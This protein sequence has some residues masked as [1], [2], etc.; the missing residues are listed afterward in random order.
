LGEYLIKN[1]NCVCDG[2]DYDENF[3][4]KA[5][6]KGY[7]NTFKIDLYQN[8]FHLQEQYDLIMFVDI[9]EHLPNPYSILKK[10][11]AENLKK[12]GAGIICL[13]N[14][15]RLEYRFNHLLGKFAYEKSGIMHQDHL[16]F[17]TQNSAAKLIYQ[18]GLTIT[19]ILPTGLGAR[20]KI[21]PSLF[22]F[23][24]IFLCRKR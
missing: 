7:R 8:N 12:G 22:A 4:I 18:S 17:F 14:I 10:I 6:Q 5:K 1:K 24:F 21:L 16:R 23:Q 19:K 3:L 20:L 11:I 2:I 9:L 13:P 15:A